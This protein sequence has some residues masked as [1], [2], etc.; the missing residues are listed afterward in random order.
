MSINGTLS[1]DQ[2]LECGVP[3][4][5][6]LGAMMYIMYVYDLS[7]TICQHKVMYQSYAD[8]T[9]IYIHCDRDH[10]S[11]KAMVHKFQECIADGCVWMNN[12]ALRLNEAKTEFTIFKPLISDVCNFK[13]KVGTSLVHSS[14]QV[15]MLGVTLDS[16]MT[17]DPQI[18]TTCRS[19]YMQIRKINSIRKF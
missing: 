9:Q 13:L 15:K 3:Q 10:L 1:E 12:S 19:T 6:V 2:N 4:G 7:I 17:I 14:N 8:D 16:K 18:S 5:S 11:I